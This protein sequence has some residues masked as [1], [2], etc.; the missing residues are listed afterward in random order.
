MKSFK[1]LHR[2]GPGKAADTACLRTNEPATHTIKKAIQINELHLLPEGVKPITAI[3]TNGIYLAVPTAVIEAQ[4]GIL[5]MRDLPAVV[6]Q[7]KRL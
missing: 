3:A 4:A 7:V 2:V 5:V 6:D 1:N